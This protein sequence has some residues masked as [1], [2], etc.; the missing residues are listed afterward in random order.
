[1]DEERGEAQKK[2]GGGDVKITFDEEL[3]VTGHQS[4]DLVA[5]DDALDALEKIDAR[6]SR[7]IG[8][9]RA[10]KRG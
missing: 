5:L 4:P 8:R 6:R 10:S 2:R 7:V 9:S 1:M 3:L